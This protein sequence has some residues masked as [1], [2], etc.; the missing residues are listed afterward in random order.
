MIPPLAVTP[1]S[2]PANATTPRGADRFSGALQRALDSDRQR[3][4]APPTDR[5]MT[6]DADA[7]APVASHEEPQENTDDDAAALAGAVT[8]IGMAPIGTPPAAAMPSV[9]S[10]EGITPLGVPSN[11]IAAAEA[12]AGAATA[13][14]FGGAVVAGDPAVTPT[15]TTPDL[16]GPR[17][18][19]PNAIE[20]PA[21]A[22]HQPPVPTD[23]AVDGV[24]ATDGPTSPQALPSAQATTATTLQAGAVRP[25]PEAA[26][27]GP[28]IDADTAPADI[29]TGGDTRP[30]AAVQRLA[31]GETPPSAPPRV[32][33]GGVEPSPLTAVTPAAPA[34]VAGPPPATSPVTGT[35]AMAATDAVRYLRELGPARAV[36]RL[37][38]DLDGATVAVRLDR[39]GAAPAVHV[40]IVDDPSG[41]LDG[42]WAA[43]VERTLSQSMQRDGSGAQPDHRNRDRPPLNPDD[44]LPAA[45]AGRRWARALG[46]EP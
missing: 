43:G 31:A 6:V 30:P 19:G 11:T 27:G 39:T 14:T 12:E 35:A 44:A 24:A 9:R 3:P 33:D 42:P 25:N 20:P 36:Q 23:A 37:A 28:R 5:D 15:A 34:G 13:P 18:P 22:V 17:T 4:T 1:P 40:H 41:R 26:A 16:D 46:G 8:I 45:L 10:T 29:P 38:V 21:G 2:E 32:A 7:T